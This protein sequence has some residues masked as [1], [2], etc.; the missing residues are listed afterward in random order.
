M[1]FPA[2][3]EYFT[4]FGL[5]NYR[6]NAEERYRLNGILATVII[7]LFLVIF[8]LF[9]KLGKVREKHQETLK[10][11]FIEDLRTIE[12]LIAQQQAQISDNYDILPREAAKNIAVNVAEKM[13]KEI[14]TEKYIEDLKKELGID[15]LNRQLDRS[16]PDD[17]GLLD[18]SPDNKKEESKKP[19]MYKGP[20]NVSYSL[21]NPVRWHRREY[22]PVYRCKKGG[23]VVVD[24]VV[25][26]TGNVLSASYSNRSNT[27]DECLVDEAVSSAYKFLFNADNK[28]ESKQKGTITFQFLSQ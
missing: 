19:Q 13:N 1:I 14:S 6:M 4:I 26:P 9:F 15:E 23:T 7:H 2:I 3:K 28:A 21:D 16:L 22:I 27:K 12:E 24:I 25:D 8:F 11:E 5:F 17:P 20:T 18:N 10:I